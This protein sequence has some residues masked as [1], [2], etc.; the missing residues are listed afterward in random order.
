MGCYCFTWWTHQEHTS[1]K[2][3]HRYQQ[4][5]PCA[6]ELHSSPACIPPSFFPPVD[7]QPGSCYMQHCCPVQTPCDG[8]RFP[9]LCLYIRACTNR[10]TAAP[11]QT[12]S[13]M[14]PRAPIRLHNPARITQSNGTQWAGNKTNMCSALL[15][16]PSELQDRL[17]S[18]PSS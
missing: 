7:A 8:F 1:I 18:Y 16:W 6:C 2:H 17:P 11:C 15:L 4:W 3:K 14:C 5:K 10:E 9:F 13:M 12:N